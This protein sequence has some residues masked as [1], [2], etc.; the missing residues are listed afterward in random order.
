MFKIGNI[1]IENNVCLAP[2]AGFC[3]SVHLEEFV[4]N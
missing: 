2:M 1:E 4:K 3:N